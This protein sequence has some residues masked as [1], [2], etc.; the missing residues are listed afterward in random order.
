MT[1]VAAIATDVV[2][3]A[4]AAPVAVVVDRAA[5]GATSA[6]GA[7]IS[8]VRADPAAPVVVVARVVVADLAADPGAMTL[9]AVRDAGTAGTA[10]RIAVRPSRSRCPRALRWTSFRTRRGLIR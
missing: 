10:A 8:V 5:H 7:P 2:A 4:H 1:P 9:V 3:H 6:A